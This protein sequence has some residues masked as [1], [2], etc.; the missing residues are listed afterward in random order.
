MKNLVRVLWALYRGPSKDPR[1]QPRIVAVPAVAVPANGLLRQ[2]RLQRRF[3]KLFWALYRTLHYRPSKKVPLRVFRVRRDQGNACGAWIVYN[4]P[5][6]NLFFATSYH[7]NPPVGSK[8]REL[9]D[10][11]DAWSAVDSLRGCLSA[12]LDLAAPWSS[13]SVNEA[14][15]RLDAMCQEIE[16][17]EELEELTFDLTNQDVSH[18]EPDAAAADTLAAQDPGIL[19][20]QDPLEQDYDHEEWG[21]ERFKEIRKMARAKDVHWKPIDPTPDG[22]ECDILIIDGREVHRL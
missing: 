5:A 8:I 15:D 4:D 16:E 7:G 21:R 11:E 6:R 13:D 20:T 17:E 14:C 19:A 3:W 9:R 22:R 2:S 18:V 10:V 1:H 12:R